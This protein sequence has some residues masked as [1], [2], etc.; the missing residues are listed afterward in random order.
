M[1]STKW[2]VLSSAENPVQAHQSD[3]CALP[4]VAAL[5]VIYTM[6]YHGILDSDWLQGVH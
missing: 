4:A 5:K 1:A 6:V 3:V 2:Q